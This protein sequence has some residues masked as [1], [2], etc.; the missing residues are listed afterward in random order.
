MKWP[1]AQSRTPGLSWTRSQRSLSPCD[2]IRWNDLPFLCSV[3]LHIDYILAPIFFSELNIHFDHALNVFVMSLYIEYC[4]NK[5][6]C[7]DKK[8]TCCYN[9]L[10]MPRRPIWHV[11]NFLAVEFGLQQTDSPI[12]F[13]LRWN[14]L[15]E[16]V[17]SS[18]RQ[19]TKLNIAKPP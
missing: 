13:D 10:H 3:G 17:P 7:N 15:S 18:L 14:L 6:P 19:P 16:I 9:V 12:T 11:H 8:I 1:L 4:G 2:I 5:Y